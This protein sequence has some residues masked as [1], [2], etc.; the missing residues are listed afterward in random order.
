M[1]V[2]FVSACMSGSGLGQEPQS[3]GSA[4]M[5][6]DKQ[7]TLAPQ[8]VI[9]GTAQDG[10]YPQAGCKKPCCKRVWEDPT[11]R[12]Y[13]SCVAITDPA[14]GDRWLLDCT[15]DF[16]EQLMLLEH[17]CTQQFGDRVNWKS[18]VSGILPT[19][20][21]VGHYAGLIHLGRE[22]MG[23]ESVPVFAMPRMYYFLESNGPWSQLVELEQIKLQRI[24]AGNPVELNERLTVVPIL[25]PHRDEFSETV[26]F[27][28][29]GPL[30]SAIYLPD[31]DKW[32][33][34]S[35]NIEQLIADV[36][37]AF[38]DGTFFSGD[39][40]QRSDAS[41]IPH[42]LV[43]ESMD[44]FRTLSIE[45]RS[46]IHFI[47]LNHTNPVLDKNSAEHQQLLQAGFE[48]AEQGHTHGL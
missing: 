9:L 1:F 41:L 26:G 28:I 35:V 33:K 11:E 40:L 18:H 48:V 2:L 45:E 43:S 25:V 42:P 10:G 39:E 32:E 37:L 30:H 13:V 46:K 31:I 7:N 21:H 16:R 5:A 34:W 47:H 8:L 36:D 22:I 27:R 29:Q 17:I 20:A 15:P 38:L 6:L 12:R 44:R 14:S 23:A 4:T 19:H 3:V 24:T